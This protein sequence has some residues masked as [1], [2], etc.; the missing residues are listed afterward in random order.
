MPLLSPP[1]RIGA[2]HV[3]QKRAENRP[4]HDKMQGSRVG[5]RKG[6]G[7]WS[8]WILVELSRMKIISINE[9]SRPQ[10]EGTA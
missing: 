8:T 5:A 10:V 4:T 1:T 6:S 3:T 7:L 2:E 9:G